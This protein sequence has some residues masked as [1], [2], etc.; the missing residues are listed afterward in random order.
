MKKE[1]KSMLLT[2]CKIAIPGVN[3]MMMMGW[4]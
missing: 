4:T 3:Q 2:H 1:K